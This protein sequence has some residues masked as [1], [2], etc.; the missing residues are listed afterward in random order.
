MFC[1]WKLSFAIAA[2]GLLVCTTVLAAAFPDVPS[3]HVYRDSIEQLVASGVIGG[4]PDGNFY[5]DRD[6]NRAEM[7]KMLYLAQGKQPDP[8]SVG[9]FP[10]VIPGS[11]YES[12]VCDAAAMRYVA[13]YSDGTF[14]PSQSVNRVEAL[15]MIQEV[16]GLPVPN[17]TELDRSVVQFVDVST[18]AWYIK[19]LFNAHVVGIL[20]IAGQD[21]SRYFPERALKRGE[22]AAMIYNAQHAEI[23]EER[24][25]IEEE[26]MQEEEGGEQAS[27]EPAT[28][29][30][31]AE[32]S[33]AVVP[34]S[35]DVTFPFEERGKFSG[36]QTYSFRFSLSNQMTI[37]TIASLQAGQTGKIQC[38]LYLM[39]DDG[40]S[41]QYYLGV[42][43]GGKCE[44]LT[45]LSPGAYQ[46]QLQPTEPDTTFTVAV[47]EAAGD[48]NDG[49]I[50]AQLLP[51]NTART[52]TL[53][54]NNFVDWYRF[55]IAGSEAQHLK[56][57]TSNTTNLT[58][59]VYAMHDVDLFGFT[60][61]QCNQYYL[62]PP[63]TYYVAIG[64]KTGKSTSQTY[65]IL[66][67][68]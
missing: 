26:S 34:I 18:S 56:V 36:K 38:T 29:E 41:E 61:P 32:N 58:C 49:F 59:I 42:Q 60:M 21:T 48:G 53:P 14:R 63:G 35:R 4:N 68:E 2:A 33:P 64:R 13:G 17:V 1:K 54:P 55:S 8:T 15:K 57:E 67:R 3:G 9:C 11:W 22:A 43:N 19:Y 46:L 24:Q 12:F 45:T 5:P 30:Q 7:L 10:D 23:R 31:M 39:E 52:A 51:R 25:Q 27:S 65:T 47:A 16:F 44:L 50:E 40:F 28:E 66:L 20:P 62:Y 37:A 6:V